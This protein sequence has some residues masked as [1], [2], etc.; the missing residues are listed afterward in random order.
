MFKLIRRLRRGARG[1]ALVE[2]ALILPLLIF[3]MLA[4]W[5]LSRVWNVYQTITRAA[6]EGARVGAVFNGIHTV[7]EIEQTIDYLLATAA[8]NPDG[9]TITHEGLGGDPGTNYTLMITY[10]YQFGLIR[11]VLGLLGGERGPPAVTLSRAITMRN[12]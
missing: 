5:E 10:P 1:Q 2:Y 6:R 9:A 12:E 3:T 4:F 7:A 8:L 11:P